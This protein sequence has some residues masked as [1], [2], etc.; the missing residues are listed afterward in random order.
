MAW[1]VNRS[2]RHCCTKCKKEKSADEFAWSDISRGLK[3]SI[4]NDCRRTLRKRKSLE[5]RKT[6]YRISNWQRDQW[7]NKKDTTL[8]ASLNEIKFW[9]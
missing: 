2:D 4:C 7:T 3:N 9:K 6:E 5:Q 1:S 8:V